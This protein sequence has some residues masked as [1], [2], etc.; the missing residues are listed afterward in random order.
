M[1]IIILCAGIGS[2]LKHLTKEN[3]KCLVNVNGVSILGR[4]LIQLF[5]L[6][7]TEKDIFLCSGYKSE[8]LQFKYTKFLNKRFRTTNMM[9][10]TIIGIQSL[11]IKKDSQEKILVI[12][13]DCIYSYESI[14]K[15]FKN[16]NNK[17]EIIIPVDL[18]WKDKW[19]KRYPN[20][21]E[22]AETLE[23]DLSSKKLIS[24]GN[25]TYIE[26]E[27]MAQFMGIYIIPQNLISNFLNSYRNFPNKIREKMSTT[28]FFN[29]TKK[30]INYLVMPDSYQWTEVDTLEDLNYAKKMFP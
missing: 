8:A 1:K 9:E 25:K 15:I 5:K 21:Y 24:I 10:T 18:D 2:R 22:D 14:N 6:G 13:G 27:Y 29:K 30:T 20:I 4:L 11:N 26:E 17:N 12:Y 28:E 7:L 23:Y 16:L 3:P 19:S